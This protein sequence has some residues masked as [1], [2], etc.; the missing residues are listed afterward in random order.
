MGNAQREGCECVPAISQ[1]EAV[2]ESMVSFYKKYNPDKL[3]RDQTKIK[4][5]KVWK[6]WQ[7]ER[8]RMF[9]ESFL[10]YRHD[11][12]EVMDRGTGKFISRGR[13]VRKIVLDGR[14]ESPTQ[15]T[16]PPPPPVE[17]KIP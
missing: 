17:P 8:P 11:A 5:R 16:T 1:D 12:L 14:K 3:N 2:M 4:D 6:Q 7:Y 15:F 13:K 9:L 10:K